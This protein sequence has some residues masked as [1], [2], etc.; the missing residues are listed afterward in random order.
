[1]LTSM[2]MPVAPDAFSIPVDIISL[3]SVFIKSSISV[4]FINKAR[5]SCYLKYLDDG[6]TR[7]PLSEVFHVYRGQLDGHLNISNLLEL[8][9]LYFST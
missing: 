9:I 4:S 3:A 7:L 6:V 8:F 5:K 1:M 2:L